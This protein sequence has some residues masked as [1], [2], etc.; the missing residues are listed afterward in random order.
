MSCARFCCPTQKELA[1]LR[2][3]LLALLISGST[4]LAENWPGWR[5]PTGQGHSNEKDLPVTWTKTQNVR[6]KAPL[7]D[8]GNSSP[9]V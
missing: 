7:P 9:I 8:A 5:G 3:T 6:W 2:I 4:L 1:M